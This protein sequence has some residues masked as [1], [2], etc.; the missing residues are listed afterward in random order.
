VL[1]LILVTMP[2]TA[3]IYQITHEDG[4]FVRG[5]TSNYKNR[6]KNHKQTLSDGN[7]DF[8][9]YIR[10]HG[11]WG[12]VTKV[13]L[14]QWECPD[15][16]SMFQEE[17]KFIDEVYE[18]P[19]CLNMKRAGITVRSSIGKLYKLTIADKWEYYG[20]TRDD[21]HRFAAHKTASKTKTSDLYKT[22]RANGGWDSVKTEI[23]REWECSE[24]EL[25]EAEDA[26]IRENWENEFLLNSIPA[27]TTPEQN[28]ELS[29]ARVRKWVE[30]HPEEAKEQSRIR[31]AK[32]REL[33]PE[34][35]KEV[36]AKS[37]AKRDSDPKKREE[38]LQYMKEYRESH[39]EEQNAKKREKRAL[40]KAQTT[41]IMLI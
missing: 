4:P 29:N 19:L 3:T 38:R 24:L 28:R 16:S 32:W 41:I 5:S 39:R 22:I 31:A 25:K 21:Y 26:L 13:I 12:K 40:A 37:R 10:E 9:K 18:D 23:I 7:S 6:M 20:R 2:F 33:N 14:K 27:S 17:G 34:K 1:Y 15:E 8:Q 30:N 35:V 36:Q 11:G